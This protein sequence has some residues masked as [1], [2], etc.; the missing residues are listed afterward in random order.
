LNV[1]ESELNLRSEEESLNTVGE[2]R[3]K[4]STNLSKSV[5]ENDKRFYSIIDR[6]EVI[7]VLLDRNKIIHFINKKACDV[8]GYKR[9]DILYKNW[10]E[11]L[12]PESL[13][14]EVNNHFE[15]VFNTQGRIQEYFENPVITKKGEEKLIGWFNSPIMDDNGVV[16][17]IVGSGQDITQK[18]REEKVRKIILKIL[19]TTNTEINLIDYFKFIHSSVGELM[20]V[21][22]FYI[23]LY[24]KEK[25]L[26]TFPYFIDKIDNEISLRRFDNGLTEYVL[27]TGDACLINND[28]NKELVE[29][30]EVELIGPTPSVWL[31]IP[32]KIQK[33]TIGVLVVQDYENENTYGEKEKE[34]LEVI[35]YAIS[36][37]I[38]RKRVEEEKNESIKKLQKLNNSKDKL[39]SMISHDLRS[40][41]NSL[42]GFSEILTT[43]Y[44]TLTDEEIQEYLGVI[45][46]A[47]KNLYSMTN[48]LLH[49]SRFQMGRFEYNP[50]RL[51][52]DRLF[53]RCLNLIKG[54]VV[55]KQINLTIDTSHA[56]DVFA[57]EDMVNSIIQNLLSNAVKFTD[58]G[59]D[60]KIF[61]RKITSLN[62]PDVV[63]I[64]VED[65]GV[66]IAEKVL[67]KL[68]KDTITSTPGTDKEYGTGLG[69][70]LVKEFVEKNGGT[71]FVR[72]KINRG[73]SFIF[74]LPAVQ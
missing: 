44:D 19:E 50:E 6:A 55:K 8:L 22:N 73:S 33:N 45:Y 28:L 53:D 67:S 30:G 1:N 18:K 9:E 38:E 69:L 11:L 40:P 16:E 62:G 24:D 68:F 2:K 34:I 41:F 74:T 70:L 49:F 58:H 66:G 42:L 57:D 29:K 59:G 3:F 52:L 54:N 36:R 64:I 32:L 71:I 7:L 72:S 23:A 27:R 13:K 39:F 15:E 25:D 37:A 17:Y 26:I 47:S 46:D 63:E 20:P 43:E 60:I 31:G 61:S 12:T 35:S 5:E 14:T 4:Y 48:N 10:E 51:K 65:T 56:N 21:E